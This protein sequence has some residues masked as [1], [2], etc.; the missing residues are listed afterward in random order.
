MESKSSK[1]KPD[2]DEEEYD[3]RKVKKEREESKSS[4][5]KPDND[6]DDFD[7]R[8]VKKERVETVPT[9]QEEKSGGRG[10]HRKTSHSSDEESEDGKKEKYEKSKHKSK[11]SSKHKSEKK[12]GESSGK[13]K[14]KSESKKKD[15]SSKHEKSKKKS[16]SHKDKHSGSGKK[17][18]LTLSDGINSESGASFAEALGMLEAPSTSKVVK[19]KVASPL[20]VDKNQSSPSS[21]K[22]KTETMVSILFFKCVCLF[23]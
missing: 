4:K 6:D 3:E 11:E 7:E 10:K 5:R 2:S 14:H 20:T 1:R 17:E 8:K 23:W 15:S 19:K 13:E 21:S 18:Q 9:S 12:K 16:E 22:L